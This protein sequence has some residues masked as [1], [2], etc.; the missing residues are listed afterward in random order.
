MTLDAAAAAAAEKL[1]PYIREALFDS[2]VLR[3]RRRKHCLG[4]LA[5]IMAQRH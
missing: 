4:A 5:V 3:R 1:F 2:R